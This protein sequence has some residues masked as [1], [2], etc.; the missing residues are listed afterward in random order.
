MMIRKS[1]F[2]IVN[3]ISLMIIFFVMIKIFKIFRLIYVFPL[4]P[5]ALSQIF[6]Q[7]FEFFI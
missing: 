4:S 1:S 3:N 6:S 7:A 5:R 2:Q